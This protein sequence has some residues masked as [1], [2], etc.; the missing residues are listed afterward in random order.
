MLQFSRKIRKKILS[1]NQ[2]TKY[3]LYAAGEIAL[4]VMGIL[5]ALQINNWNDNRK[6]NN[7][8]QE[9][10][11]RLHD[12]LEEE[13]SYIE[14]FITYNEKVSDFA[15]EAIEFFEY[16]DIAFENSQNAL[17][18]LYQA[19]QFNDARTT[20][21][22][23]KE[24]NSS[25]QINLIKNYNLRSSIISYYELDWTNSVIFE[26]PNNYRTTLRSVM[27]STIQL[28]MMKNCGDVYVQTKKSIAVELPETC[29]INIDPKL[30]NKVL[31]RL[32]AD[33]KLKEDLNF[34]IGNMDSKLA[35]MTY[36]RQQLKKVKQELEESKN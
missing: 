21:S 32:L 15:K 3:L 16:G 26:I 6:N 5:I 25:G 31:S 30:A 7:L 19:S 12:D 22:T 17:I 34:L 2:T 23:Y 1:K 24:L 20:S 29:N 8:E 9:Y 13:E 10:L 27:P 14:S 35:Y 33:T 36:I 28:E 18:T 11:I 4:V